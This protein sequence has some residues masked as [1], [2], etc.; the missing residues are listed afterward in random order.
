MP[1]S[2]LRRL[3]AETVAD[4]R[5][6]DVR[7]GRT[8]AVPFADVWDALVR[9]IRRR[10]GW[11]LVHADEELGLLTA[12]CRSVRPR[13]PDDLSVWVALDENGLTSVEVRSASR[14]PGGDLGANRR[15][16]RSLLARLDRA[17]R[18]GARVETA[19]APGDSPTGA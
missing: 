2:E 3:F 6:G 16:V 1:S 10:R 11:R 4:T 7:P 13:R 18:P 19:R 9:D 5:R 15:R 12:L 8:Y 17:V 14:G